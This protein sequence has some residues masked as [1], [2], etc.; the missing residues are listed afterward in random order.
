L[1]EKK[2]S[3]TLPNKKSWA[4][5]WMMKTC[6]SCSARKEPHSLTMSL[7]YCGLLDIS[8][9]Y[10]PDKMPSSSRQRGRY[11]ATTVNSTRRQFAGFPCFSKSI[12]LIIRSYK[13]SNSDG[14]SLMICST[15]HSG[16]SLSSLATSDTYRNVPSALRRIAS[17]TL[18]WSS[19]SCM[20]YGS[21]RQ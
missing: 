6:P 10:K 14:I 13:S 21:D 1:H 9:Y 2:R 17:R 4:D 19:S 7:T 3:K 18:V 15:F 12:C 16:A 11:A 20:L 5:W 8:W